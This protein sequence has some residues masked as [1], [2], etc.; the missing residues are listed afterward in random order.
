[1]CFTWVSHLEGYIPVTR[2]YLGTDHFTLI[3]LWDPWEDLI[4]YKAGNR[5]KFEI[6]LTM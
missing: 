3:A 1:L 4:S 2:I 6:F 5:T